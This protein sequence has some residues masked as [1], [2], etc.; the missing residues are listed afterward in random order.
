MTTVHPHITSH[1]APPP[2][3]PLA[4]STAS[5]APGPLSQEHL[6]AL[7]DARVRSAKVRRAASVATLSGWTMALFAGC[8]A[9]GVV[10]GDIS[11]L[12]ISIGLGIV[13]CNELRGAAMLRRFDLR[14]PRLLG[15]NQFGL[16]V[17]IVAYAGWSI[18]S[19][20]H[21]SALASVGSTGDKDIDELVENLNTTITY[22]L[23]GSIAALGIIAPGLT[24]W[25]YFSRAKVVRAMVNSTPDWVIQTLRAAG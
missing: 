19:A 15:F 11:S 20:G 12:V 8:T 17:L 1:I 22:G 9:L 25:Y 4:P 14:G 21:S 18:I 2:T 24:A 16:G 13:A 3:Q 5:T 6:A 7:A 10:F 23:Y